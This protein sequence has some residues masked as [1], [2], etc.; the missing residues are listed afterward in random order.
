MW[1]R[2]TDG[3]GRAGEAPVAVT[4]LA[5][6]RAPPAPAPAPPPALFLPEDAA[7]GTLIAA[8]PDPAA[9]NVHRFVSQYL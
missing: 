1:V 8:L 4:L 6:Q 5:G 7:P 2:A 3:G 9:A